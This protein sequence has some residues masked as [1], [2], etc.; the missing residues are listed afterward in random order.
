M[1]SSHHCSKKAMYWKDEDDSDEK[2]KQDIMD[3]FEVYKLDGA[4]I[5]ASSESDFSDE[6]GKNPPHMKARKQYELIIDS[7]CFLCT[8]EHPNEKKPEPIILE[9]NSE[10]LSYQKSTKDNAAQKSALGAAVQKARGED[11]PP[12]EKTGFGTLC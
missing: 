11:E 12:S 2:L 7:G 3:D 5:I 10:G 9:F 8:H 6:E 1:L 4:Y